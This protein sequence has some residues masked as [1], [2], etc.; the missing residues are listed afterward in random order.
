[1]KKLTSDIS[2]VVLH[3]EKNNEAH[4]TSEISTERLIVRRGQP[5]L[6]TLH[7]S[8]ALKPEA[9]ELTVQTGP[10]PSEDLGTKA[11]FRVSRKRR[12]NKSWDVKVQETSDMSVTLAISSPADASIGEYTLSV[13]E[14]HSAGSFVVLFNP[15][16]AAGLL[17][18]FC[19]EVF[20]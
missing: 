3:C 13:G 8:S 5:F 6:L 12:I 18:G 14:G 11:V 1:M 17:R 19:G 15:W 20:T 2:E 9:L 16:C 10:E 4:R 7:S